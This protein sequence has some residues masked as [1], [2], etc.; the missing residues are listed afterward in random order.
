MEC[1]PL[2]G[3]LGLPFE[4]KLKYIPQNGA[5]LLFNYRSC[6]NLTQKT[7]FFKKPIFFLSPLSTMREREG[8]GVSK[9]ETVSKRKVNYGDF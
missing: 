2:K 4:M 9:K 7:T 5:I 3:N 6:S 8:E 1:F